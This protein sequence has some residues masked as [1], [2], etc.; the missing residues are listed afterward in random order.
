M[1]DPVGDLKHE[2]LAAAARRLGH[3]PVRAGRRRLRE[4]LP[5]YRLLLTS[6]TLAIA[7]AA[8]L[9]V[10]AAWND[11]PG[12]LARAEAALRPPAGTVLH[13]KWEVTA[14][15]KDPTCTVTRGPSESWIDQT[16]PHR[17]RVLLATLPP[18]D[19]TNPIRA[20]SPAR[21]GRPTRSAALSTPAKRSGSCRRT[22]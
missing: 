5:G 14:T 4:H 7:T 2:L 3:A 6:A 18:S 20:R 1:S 10:I 13:Q 16:P 15:S 17:Y 8:A 9:L 19:A 21:S 22:R 12:F 11:S